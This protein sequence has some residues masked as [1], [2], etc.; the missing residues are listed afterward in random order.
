MIKCMTHFS[1][2]GDYSPFFF[3]LMG[4]FY[5]LVIKRDA[6]FH[7]EVWIEYKIYFWVSAGE[8]SLG[9]TPV[10]RYIFEKEKC[11][12]ELFLIIK[13]TTCLRKKI[14]ESSEIVVHSSLYNFAHIS[15]ELD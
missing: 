5:W 4:V 8:E 10:Q 9:S 6:C 13:V 7:R 2:P 3:F 14:L 12:G 15:R 1:H 11:E